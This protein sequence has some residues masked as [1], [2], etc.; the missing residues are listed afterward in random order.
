MSIDRMRRVLVPSIAVLVLAVA[1]VILGMAMSDGARAAPQGT[2]APSIFAVQVRDPLLVFGDPVRIAEDERVESIVAF[3]GD[4]TV[5][6]TV[7]RSV[8]AFGGDVLLLPT[9]SVGD[10][11][12]E[13]DTTVVSFGGA[14]TAR[15]GAQVTGDLERIGEDDW[16][17]ALDVPASKSGDGGAWVVFS[18]FWWLAQAALV[19]ILGVLAAAL[20]PRQMLAVGR[21][22]SARPGAS[23]G[24][25]ALVFFIIV[26]AAAI[27]LLI[28]IVGILVLIPAIVVVPIFY[29]LATLSVAAV[30]AQRL[31]KGE[32]RSNLILATVLGAIGMIVISL[33]PVAGAL[34]LLVVALFGTGAAIL[35]LLEWRRGR[36]M[37]S[38]PAPVGGP[39]EGGG[40]D[41]SPPLA[42]PLTPTPLVD[43]PL[44]GQADAAPAASE[45]LAA[46][47]G[48]GPTVPAIE[49][50]PGEPTTASEE[51]ADAGDVTAVTSTGASPESEE[52]ADVGEATPDSG[53]EEASPDTSG[54]ED[55]P[56]REP[57]EGGQQPVS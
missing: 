19:L 27:V 51:P 26:P 28:S 9:A 41:A 21:T 52:P 54:E 42:A 18:F 30:I 32:R 47:L 24:W 56:G 53:S 11:Q 22:V 3:G 8:V 6:G 55:A 5:A 25:G 34:A 10:A 46:D 39:A 48:E 12:S 57:P 20:L 17:T 15:E 23:L 36:R 45:E 7:T 31:L 35:A 29:L 16:S 33:I 1:L 40:T 49:A 13:T 4:V 37:T 2:T 38:A 44:A 50:P 43:Q 14:I